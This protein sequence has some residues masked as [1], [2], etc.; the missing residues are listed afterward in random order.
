MSVP[1]G[2]MP[3]FFLHFLYGM[4]QAVAIQPHIPSISGSNLSLLTLGLFTL[5]VRLQGQCLGSV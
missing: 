5:Q 3:R 2:E 1:L 4:W